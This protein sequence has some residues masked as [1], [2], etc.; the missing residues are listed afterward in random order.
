[1]LSAVWK[2]AVLGP[3]D[4]MARAVE[5]LEDNKNLGIALVVDEDGKLIE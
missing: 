1:M 2:N 4:S 5:V 3:S